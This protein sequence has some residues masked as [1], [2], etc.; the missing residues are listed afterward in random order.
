GL[1]EKDPMKRIGIKTKAAAHQNYNEREILAET[2]DHLILGM[3]IF[4]RDAHF[5]RVEIDDTYPEYL[6]SHLSEY[7]HFVLQKITPFMRL[8]HKMDM[9]AGR[10]CRK[11]F[12][13]V[14][15]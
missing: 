11:A 8:V 13:K 14:F 3:D 9:T 4:G 15:G 5:E 1:G 12:H 7:Q 2:M 6:R 10:F